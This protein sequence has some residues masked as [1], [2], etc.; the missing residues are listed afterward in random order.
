MPSGLSRCRAVRRN[1]VASSGRAV[2]TPVMLSLECMVMCTK[3]LLSGGP[4]AITIRTSRPFASLTHLLKRQMPSVLVVLPSQSRKVRCLPLR[5]RG[6]L[7]TVRIL[8]PRHLLP[9]VV[10]SREALLPS[11]LIRGSWRERYILPKG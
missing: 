8:P 3:R 9:S 2:R 6:G 4:S 1:P 5:F 7:V 10:L 11:A